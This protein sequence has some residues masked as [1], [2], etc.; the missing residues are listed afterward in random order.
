MKYAVVFTQ[1]EKTS[2]YQVYVPDLP[3]CAISEKTID[4]GI[5][6][7]TKTIKSHLTILAEYGE[8]VPNS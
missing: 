1:S 3:G 7:I 2:D 4:L 5:E 8:K 6:E